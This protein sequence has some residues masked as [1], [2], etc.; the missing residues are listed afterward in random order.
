M[1][2][3]KQHQ[4][5]YRR[6]R[7]Q[8]PAEVLG[9]DHVV[10]ALTGRDPR[11]P[12]RIT[13]S[14]SAVP[15]GPARPRPRASSPRWS[16]ASRG[17]PP[18]RAARAR[19]ASRIREG[20]H[21]DVVEIDAAQPRRGRGRA[22]APR[23]G[24]DRAGPGPREGLH[25]RR[26][27][28]ALAR[29]VRRPAEGLRG[30]AAR[31]A[32]RARH[33]RAAQ[34]AGHD[35]RT[36][37]SGSTSA[38]FDLDTLT[39]HLQTIAAA[40]GVTLTESA[41]H[42]IARQAEGSV[43]DA[44]SLLDQAGVLGGAT[45]DDDV[46]ARAARR[47]ARR[48]AARARRR[49][50]GR[51]RQGRVRDREPAGRRTGRTSATSPPRRSRTSATCC[52]SRRR[53]ASPTC[54]TC[55]TTRTSTLRIQAEKFTP[56]RARAGASRC[57]WRPRTTCAGRRR[58]ASRSSSRWCERRSPRPTSDPAG[59]RRPARAARTPRQPRSG[60][61][62]AARRP[63]SAQAARRPRARPTTVAP[64]E[65]AAEPP[66][67]VPEASVES[68]RMR[69]PDG[70]PTAPMRGRPTR[71]PR[72]ARRPTS[73]QAADQA[74]RPD[75]R[76]PHAA[77]AGSVDVAMLRRSWPSLLDHLGQ[78]R[79]D[80][81]AALLETATVAD[82]R[83]RR[84]SSSRSRPIAR[85]GLRKVEESRPSSQAA[86]GDLFG[87]KPRI[88]CV[89][90]EVRDAGG[91]R[92]ASRSSRRTRSAD[93]GGGAAAAPGDARGARRRT[94]GAGGLAVYEGPI[95]ELIDELAR[96]PG[97]GP[98]SAQRLAF[99]LVK[100]DARGREAPRRGD[101]AG[102]GPHRV[103]PGVRQRRRGRPLPDLPRR[104]ARPHDAL[105]G[106]GAEGRRH[107]REGG[108]ASRGG[109]TSSAARSARSTASG[110][111]ICACRSCSTASSAT[112]SPR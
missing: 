78:H 31:R 44:L 108:A 20:T 97:V 90:R 39:G 62:R 77:D 13:R 38:A 16:T 106:R 25:H 103:L 33:H 74:A 88:V 26:G 47:A 96:L 58:R 85:S 11:G 15:A 10:R 70:P 91:G 105:R 111:T 17:P 53:R 43:R 102:E 49:G 12:A 63:T 18:S 107:D 60:G 14:C 48:G 56:R 28:A 27:A 75:A 81:P 82:V 57:C 22:R 2:D 30:A 72:A 101:R 69:P 92:R 37:A 67:V 3:E 112:T 95:Q 19:S 52:W 94:D 50:R 55:P 76:C 40:E 32:V 61:R 1:A 71:G 86:L 99:W 68:S 23:E 24:A 42:A 7:P 65:L 59:A 89:V 9:Q 109:S 98:K 93:R 83:R 45:I 66:V 84:P 104:V 6:Y 64:V 110:P 36:L 29:G 5:L 100:A 34:D 51:R 80:D 79:A 35:R 87:I 4:A 8:T 54:S 46:V 41:A 73:R 21:L